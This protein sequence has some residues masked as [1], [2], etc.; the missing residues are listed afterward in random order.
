MCDITTH[1]TPSQEP[2]N[3][4]CHIP[5]FTAKNTSTFNAF[6]LISMQL[7]IRHNKEISK[8]ISYSIHSFPL[9]R[10]GNE[11]FVNDSSRKLSTKPSF[12]D[13]STMTPVYLTTNTQIGFQT[14]IHVAAL[15]LTRPI[16]YCR[17]QDDEIVYINIAAIRSTSDMEP[18]RLLTQ[19]SYPLCM[20]VI[21]LREFLYIY[22]K[23]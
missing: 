6:G 19:T 14:A 1:Y 23:F 4:R 5:Q 21:S 13:N 7:H 3:A 10:A 9:E 11:C 8:F 18:K 12:N 20:F 15:G 2:Q 22:H 16:S 17:K